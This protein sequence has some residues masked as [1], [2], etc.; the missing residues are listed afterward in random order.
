MAE[1]QRGEG[2]EALPYGGATALNEQEGRGEAAAAGADVT[3]ELALEN[4]DI[5]VLFAPGEEEPLEGPTGN[6]DL[7]IL[8]GGPDPDFQAPVVKQRPGRVPRYT[9]R[10]LAQFRAAALAPGAPPTLVALYRATIRQLEA[11][12]RRR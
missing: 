9:V 1:Y 10:H 3:G 12:R 5:P 7:E 11:E 8:L 6:D 2:A 4:Q